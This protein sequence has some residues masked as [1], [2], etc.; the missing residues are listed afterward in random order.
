MESAVSPSAVLGTFFHTPVYGTFELLERALVELD[1]HGLITRVTTPDD[2]SY[3]GRVRTAREGRAL[4]ELPES[5]VALPGFIDLHSHAPQWPQAGIAL[6]EPL[7]VWL[8]QR[9]FPLEAR[10]A[11]EGFALPVYEDLV[12]TF[13]SRGTTTCVYFA[14]AH[15]DSSV[16]LA[17]TAAGGAPGGSR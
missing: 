2:P 9:T 12:R 14:S 4:L 10:F 3:E 6:D 13:L 5:R 16:A 17:R 15:L 1:E 11:D 8:D 7:D